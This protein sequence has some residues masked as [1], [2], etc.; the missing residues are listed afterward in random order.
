MPGFAHTSKGHCLHGCYFCVNYLSI[1]PIWN[2]SVLLFVAFPNYSS[3]DA[4]NH[5]NT[6]ANGSH[7][8]A[9][10]QETTACDCNSTDDCQN[11]CKCQNDANN[12]E[13]SILFHRITLLCEIQVSRNVRTKGSRRSHPPQMNSFIV[14]N[15][16]QTL[17][18]RLR[19]C[20]RDG[21]LRDRC[22]P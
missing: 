14:M 11:G 8:V 18:A 4:K 17:L 6:N 5:R 22:C 13:N 16:T 2:W 10:I 20:K 9:Q 7:N 1:R 15:S 12:F 19:P 21:D 3:K